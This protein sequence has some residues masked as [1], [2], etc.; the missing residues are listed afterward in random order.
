MLPELL[1][2]ADPAGRTPAGSDACAPVTS[3]TNFWRLAEIDSAKFGGREQ[4]VGTVRGWFVQTGDIAC[5]QS[6]F[7]QFR[8]GPARADRKAFAG[9]MT[10]M[11][12]A[13][14]MPPQMQADA[15]AYHNYHV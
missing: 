5:M 10:E 1:L 2:R 11:N 7:P 15:V 6:R 13:E 8:V 3:Q 14:L 9:P 4:S 12:P